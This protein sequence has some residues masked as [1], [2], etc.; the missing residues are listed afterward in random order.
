MWGSVGGFACQCMLFDFPPPRASTTRA[1]PVPDDS[2][3]SRSWRTRWTSCT[4]PATS[5]T[6]PPTSPCRPWARTLAPAGCSTSRCPRSSSRRPMP[7]PGE[8]GGMLFCA[9]KFFGLA[10]LR[11]RSADGGARTPAA[12]PVPRTAGNGRC[13]RLFRAASEPSGSPPSSRS[14]DLGPSTC[15]ATSHDLA[16]RCRRGR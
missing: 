12:G 10:G 3:D 7:S 9:C 4:S 16:G 13:V 14:R 8:R 15:S 11:N 6:L 2:C 5:P 1:P